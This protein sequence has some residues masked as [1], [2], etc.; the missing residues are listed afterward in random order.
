MPLLVLHPSANVPLPADPAPLLGTL[1]RALA[2]LTGKSE[3]WVM[4]RLEPAR[5][6]TF[7]GSDDPCCYVECK[8]IGLDAT[9]AAR[10]SAELTP[11][12]AA[13]L[14]VP[15]ERVYVGFD[16]PAGALW[17]HGSETFG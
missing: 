4:T 16:G 3:D 12:I 8:S 10:S 14:E 1:S 2:E 15:L 13:A 5:P 17:G 6:M 9:L 11:R 7:G